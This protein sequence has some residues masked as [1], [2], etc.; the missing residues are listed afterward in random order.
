M[1]TWASPSR[2]L[3]LVLGCEALFALPLAFLA[4]A[5]PVPLRAVGTYLSGVGMI[6]AVAIGLAAW[7]PIA[8]AI[9][10]STAL[11]LAFAL[12]IAS[13]LALI[14]VPEVRRVPAEP[15]TATTSP[16]T[17]WHPSR[18]PVADLSLLLIPWLVYGQST[19]GL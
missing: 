2:P 19:L 8:A 6:L 9:G 12:F 3:L 10:L 4:A 1:A 17:S 13:I 16:W 18:A 7:G 15:E 11:W 14:T 5:T